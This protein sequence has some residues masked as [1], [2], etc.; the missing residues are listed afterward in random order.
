MPG[1]YQRPTK[2]R[3]RSGASAYAL[4]DSKVSSRTMMMKPQIVRGGKNTKAKNPAGLK[5]HTDKRSSTTTLK[6]P[7]KKTMGH[8]CKTA[9]STLRS[10]HK[11]CKTCKKTG[12]CPPAGRKLRKCGK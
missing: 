4:P 6:P 2:V 10:C 7:G 3:S 1:H 9:G 12:K 11:P 8:N 5:L